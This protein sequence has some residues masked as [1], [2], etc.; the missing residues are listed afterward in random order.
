MLECCIQAMEAFLLSLFTAI[1]L[2][3]NT[4]VGVFREPEIYSPCT[5]SI[6]YKIGTIDQ[7]FNLSEK[8]LL[9]RV[10]SAT[11]IWESALGRPVFVYDPTGVPHKVTRRATTSARIV[12]INLVYDDRQRL[13]S[14][15]RQLEGQVKNE[16]KKVEADVAEYKRRVA[17]FNQRSG[18]LSEKI[19]NL[20]IEDPEYRQKFDEAFKES[21]ELNKEADTLNQLSATLNQSTDSYNA[22]VGKLNSTISKFNTTLAQ[23]PEEGIYMSEGDIIEIYITNSTNELV[24]TLAH[25]FGHALGI[26]HIEDA[27]SIMYTFTTQTVEAAPEDVAA[28]QVACKERVRE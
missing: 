14:Q 27:D 7:K 20:S 24:H 11:D 12:T 15:I 18:A 16:N 10:E 3:F 6:R 1:T 17:D 25:E 28:I 22:E 19:K 5:P 9:G 4:L 23:R 13:N 26:E 21:E 2:F 8:K